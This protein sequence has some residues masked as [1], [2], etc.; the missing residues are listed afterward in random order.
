VEENGSV[1]NVL[2]SYRPRTPQL[3]IFCLDKNF[4]QDKSVWIVTVTEN[5]LTMLCIMFYCPSDFI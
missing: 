1:S 2:K 4:Y 3:S 5:R